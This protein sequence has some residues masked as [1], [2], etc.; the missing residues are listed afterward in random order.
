[1]GIAPADFPV[2]FATICITAVFFTDSFPLELVLSVAAI[3]CTLAARL[4]G[5]KKDPHVAAF[6]DSIKLI[7]YPVCLNRRRF[8]DRS[9]F[10]VSTARDSK[11]L[12][13]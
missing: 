10:S 12:C 8:F 6:T 9:E 4:I 3:S 2:Y 7:A 11:V 1:L 13:G 5:M